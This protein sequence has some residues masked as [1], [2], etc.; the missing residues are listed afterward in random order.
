M[1][2][3][4]VSLMSLRQEFVRMSEKKAVSFAEM[5]QR[6]GIS[7]KTGYKWRGRCRN[8]AAGG[9]IVQS[10][11]PKNIPGTSAIATEQSVLSLR[12]CHPRWGARKI[13]RLLKTQ[14]EAM[15]AGST[16]TTLFHRHGLM[17]PSTQA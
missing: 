2:W 8:Q 3:G 17:E 14:A 12:Q 6:Y 16:I 5:C 1:P 10:R 13:R 9:L 4:A 15:P 11:R 7:R